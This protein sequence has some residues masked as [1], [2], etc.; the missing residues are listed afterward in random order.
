MKRMAFF[1]ASAVLVCGGAAVW[2]QGRGAA[3]SATAATPRN[4]YSVTLTTVKPDHVAEW[5]EIQKSQTIPMQ[6]KGGIKS[7]D[8]WQSGAPFGDGNTYGI[9]TPIDKF[10]TYDMPPMALRIMG[11]AAGRAYQN[12]LAAMT[13]S[14]RTFAVQD[15]AELS[16]PPAPNAKI[17]AAILADV[18]IVSGH[19]QQYEAYLKDDLLPLLKKDKAVG[20]VVSRTVFGGNA[21]EYHE[22]TYLASFADIDKGPAQARLLTPT[23][24]AAMAAKITPHVAHVERTILRHVPD[25]SYAARPVS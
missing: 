22:V 3:Q 19:Q 12:K 17:V 8:T 1:A 9:V 4:W 2:A 16:M 21:N 10:A 13:L 24:R 25:L 14:R 6:Q 11:D 5:L 18:T 7:R 23:E 15:R 20:F